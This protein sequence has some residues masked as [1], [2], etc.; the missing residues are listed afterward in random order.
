MFWK[1][2]RMNG[3]L[4]VAILSVAGTLAGGL[5]SAR[6]HPGEKNGMER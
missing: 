6:R 1:G 3:I 5:P 2:L 4:R